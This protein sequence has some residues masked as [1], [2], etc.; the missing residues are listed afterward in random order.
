LEK[1]DI[2]K[3][4]Q[5]KDRPRAKIDPERKSTRAKIDKA[6]IDKER[7]TKKGQLKIDLFGRD[8]HAVLPGKNWS[9]RFAA[10]FQ[11][12]VYASAS[13]GAIA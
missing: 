10:D 11:K 13:P 4:N 9:G 7:L 5:S 12:H 6:K 3:I 1:Q 8:R 2:L